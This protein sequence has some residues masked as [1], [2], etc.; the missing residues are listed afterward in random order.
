[1]AW[2]HPD[3]QFDTDSPTCQIFWVEITYVEP[4][5]V[6]VH[7]RNSLGRGYGRDVLAVDLWSRG[8]RIGER[9]VWNCDISGEVNVANCEE[10]C[11][12]SV[13]CEDVSLFMSLDVNDRRC[14]W[15]TCFVGYPY[16]VERWCL[17]EMWCRLVHFVCRRIEQLSW[18]EVDYRIIWLWLRDSD[19]QVKLEGGGID[20]CIISDALRISPLLREIGVETQRLMHARVGGIANRCDGK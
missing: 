10:S 20:E 7:H 3:S 19:R 8:F 9:N 16:W 4:S 1:M 5:S 15:E 12:A 6:V 18:L 13:A 14:G 11:V 17:L 2:K